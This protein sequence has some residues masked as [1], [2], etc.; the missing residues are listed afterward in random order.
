M[1][2]AC[3][4]FA[5]DKTNRGLKQAAGRFMA[6]LFIY[7]LQRSDKYSMTQTLRHS[8]QD[9]SQYYAMS[10]TTLAYALLLFMGISAAPACAEDAIGTT[11]PLFGNSSP[12]RSPHV[13]RTWKIVGGVGVNI[14]SIN[15][16]ARNVRFMPGFARN[17]DPKRGYFPLESFHN[18]VARYQPRAA[19]N[20]TY[21]HLANG[22]PTGTIVRYSQY[23]YQGQCGAALCFDEGGKV[24]FRFSTNGAP[25]SF[26]GV[27]HAIT[28]GPT[29][30]RHGEV[31]LHPIDEGF[32]DPSVLG[33]A[34]RS[35][36]GLT[37]SGKL[38]LVTVHTPISLNKLANILAKSECETAVNLDGGSS[39]GLYSNGLFVTLPKRKLSN[40]ILVYD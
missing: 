20:G 8:R 39:S 15:T 5:D 34:R 26:T 36:V 21:F 38:L 18:I 4:L 6:K 14:V 9:A 35:A 10:Y 31:Y 32:T 30:V 12:M 22:Q 1:R 7:A 23:L 16:H 24:Q 11:L 28:T 37:A 17:A 29:L 19:I 13:T 33:V 3:A 2:C 27:Q 25:L 40:V